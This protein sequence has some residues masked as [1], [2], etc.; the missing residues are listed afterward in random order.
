[1][2]HLVIILSIFAMVIGADSKIGGTTYFDYTSGKIGEDESKNSEKKI[3]NIT[4]KQIAELENKLSEK[5][6]EIMTI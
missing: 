6:K 5:E 4:D 1:M 2:K 3:Q